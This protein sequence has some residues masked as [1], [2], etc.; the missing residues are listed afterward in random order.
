MTEHRV[1]LFFDFTFTGDHVAD[2]LV[3]TELARAAD[4]DWVHPSRLAADAARPIAHATLWD[5]TAWHLSPD[6]DPAVHSVLT[7]SNSASRDQALC[8]CWSAAARALLEGRYR[9]EAGQAGHKAG[10]VL[11]L[12]TGPHWRDLAARTSALLDGGPAGFAVEVDIES[13]T[14]HV[15]D[16]G[17]G[18]VVPRLRLRPRQRDA[19]IPPELLVELVPRLGDERRRAAFAWLDDWSVAGSPRFSLS[20]LMQ[21]LVEPAGGRLVKRERTYTYTTLVASQ[22]I[23]A[24]RDVA[25]RLS[26]HYGA[27]YHPTSDFLGT[28]FVQPFETVL[29]AASREAGCTGVPPGAGPPLEF[30]NNWLAQA[31]SYAYFPLQ[32]AAMHEYVA[33][34]GMAQGVLLP[35]DPDAHDQHT[36]AALKNLNHR[37]LLFR[38]RYRL[39]HVS[40]ITAHELAFRATVEA[41]GIE[42]LSTKIARDLVEVER[43]LIELA[44]DRA[45][46]AEAE[47]A[48]RER[49]RERK[50]AALTGVGSA[51]LSYIT[52]ATFG[53]H[54]AEFLHHYWELPE[55][56]YF[57]LEL[58]C[59]LLGIG[60][61]AWSFHYSVFWK[62]GD[63]HEVEHVAEHAENELKLAHH[64][65][66]PPAVR[67]ASTRSPLDH[68]TPPTEP[69]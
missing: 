28:I 20:G 65:I 44:A 10:L 6:F 33:L 7:S 47:S 17:V 56:V 53:D 52:M 55:W 12:G 67:V 43:R 16:T 23:A 34:L 19:D 3:R 54:F 63:H 27:S 30:L 51:A 9:A 59:Q 35:I 2:R 57:C 4:A 50:Y 45:Q 68:S 41:L 26:R 38:L 25:Y 21:R 5:W 11:A 29:H 14:A 48:A 40:R 36:I 64:A 13:I 24:P 37:F 62:H 32:V 1:S 61:A 31:D 69:G 18:L 39:V 66:E 49:R 60:L 46:A 8:L 15:F 58:F 22:P 42:A